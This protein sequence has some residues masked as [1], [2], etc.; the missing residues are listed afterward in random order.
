MERGTSFVGQ[1]AVSQR[2]EGDDTI[3]ML[4]IERFQIAHASHESYFA[5][6][7]AATE[8]N[9]ARLAASGRTTLRSERCL[10]MLSSHSASSLR[11]KAAM[12]QSMTLL[13][14]CAPRLR[15]RE[16]EG[17]YFEQHAGA[18]KS[19]FSGVFNVPFKR[20]L[21]SCRLNSISPDHLLLMAREWCFGDWNFNESSG[22]VVKVLESAS[23]RGNEEAS[24]LLGVMTEH[25]V[26]PEFAS[27]AARLEWLVALMIAK[28]PIA[29]TYK[30]FALSFLGRY[31]EA[32]LL[33][34]ASEAG[35]A[36]AMAA[37]GETLLNSGF[38]EVA[39]PWFITAADLND[40]NGCTHLAFCYDHGEGVERDEEK[41]FALYLKGEE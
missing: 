14:A 26:V 29:M 24:W 23:S 5:R 7:N 10:A 11:L 19:L 12:E 13:T 33:R 1:R 28:S 6:L 8:R 17:I 15:D 41:A 40:P 36:P 37:W 34:Q 32:T 39:I 38:H 31:E 27:L 4:G 35:Y 30:G 22:H 9:M 3:S 2:G 16:K 20:S 21:R 18:L 25:G